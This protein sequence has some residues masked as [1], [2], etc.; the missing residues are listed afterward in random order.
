MSLLVQQLQNQDPS[1]PTDSS[2]L[3][4]QMLSYA[5]YSQQVAMNDTLSSLSSTMNTLSSTVSDLYSS[6][7]AMSSKLSV[8]A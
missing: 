6:V 4:S 8:S 7:S 3:A 1:N 5:G 2:Q